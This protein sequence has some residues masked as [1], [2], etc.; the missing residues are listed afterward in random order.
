MPNLPANCM[1][2]AVL[3]LSICLCL[4]GCSARPSQT[5]PPLDQM[6]RLTGGSAKSAQADAR[7]AQMQ[8]ALDVLLEAESE[9]A[10]IDNSSVRVHG[11][12]IDNAKSFGLDIIPLA[13]SRVWEQ[14][15]SNRAVPFDAFVK[16]YSLCDQLLVEAGED[17]VFW[18]G[19]ASEEEVNGK[20][21]FTPGW[22]FFD[23]GD[24]EEM[25][26]FMHTVMNDIYAK[27]TRALART[28]PGG[29]GSTVH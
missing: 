11:K 28:R 17:S 2:N 12:A 3:L 23:P 15:L 25:W 24:P 21:R 19:G 29:K 6:Q 1:A 13:L 26:Q 18:T 9:G 27:H 20:V 7:L 4:T 8:H 22:G 10:S 14:E 5:D 16:L